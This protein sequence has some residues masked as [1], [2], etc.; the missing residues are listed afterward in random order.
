MPSLFS[1]SSKKQWKQAPT[2]NGRPYVVG[3]VPASPSIREVEFEGL[4]NNT[5]TKVISVNSKNTSARIQ[6][7]VSTIPP[8][9]TP[10]PVIR[11]PSAPLIKAP[12]PE[13]FL[14]L[15]PPPKSEELHSDSTQSHAVL[16]EKKSRF[17]LP[18]SPSNRRS[19]IPA[20]YSQVDF[21]TRM[22][23]YSDDEHN[24]DLDE[25]EHTKQ[26]RRESRD[27]A[28]VDI[29][30]GTQARRLG[31]QDADLDGQRH[32]M[33]PRRS[34]PDMASLEVAQVLAAVKNRSPSPTSASDRVDRDPGM[35]QHFGGDYDVDEVETVP[36]Q[37]SSRGHGDGDESDAQLAYEDSVGH[38]TEEDDTP[39]AI[40]QARIMAARR[41][42]YFD[43]H[44]ERRRMIPS[45]VEE[46]PRIKLAQDDSDDEDEDDKP[47]Q[48]LRPLPVPP[49]AVA[50]PV[51]FPTISMKTAAPPASPTPPEGKVG[52]KT[53]ALIEMYRERERGAIPPAPT[54]APPA[55]PA[56]AAAPSRLPVR[57]LPV[58]VPVVS[59]PAPKVAVAS[60]APSVEATLEMPRIPLEETGRSSPARYVHGAPLHNVIEEEEEG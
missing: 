1:A 27:D 19:M 28:W 49:P 6:S 9:P 46:D 38:G 42:G 33:Q 58:P 17:K 11:K 45:M 31:G 37:S 4:L 55:P 48:S 2:L 59:A 44:P 56:A 52:S 26:K 10:V 53:A 15:P 34:D 8:A 12:E 36:R 14:G 43:M 24:R 29:L 57:A 25:P 60:P 51:Q 35:D 18:V 3:A 30:V 41:V 20:E 50:A 32:G 22:A 47:S 40:R 5:S 23:S 54:A 13:P 21:E 7:S 16:R 39:E